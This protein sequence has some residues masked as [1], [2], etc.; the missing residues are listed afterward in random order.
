MKKVTV[1]FKDRIILLKPEDTSLNG[2]MAK[3]AYLQAERDPNIHVD[4]TAIISD[5]TKTFFVHRVGLDLMVIASLLSFNIH[6]SNGK[7]IVV[8]D[9]FSTRSFK[10]AL[11]HL[12]G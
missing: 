6:I 8:D 10:Q 4:F 11:Q 2:L 7:F 3:Q 9:G 1:N 5:E 12:M